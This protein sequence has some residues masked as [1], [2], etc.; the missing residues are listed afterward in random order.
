[1]FN[2]G[3]DG[4][5]LLL[6]RAKCSSLPLSVQMKRRSWDYRMGYEESVKENRL[7]GYREWSSLILAI[8]G[9]E[10]APLKRDSRE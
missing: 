1:M 4:P 8:S 9:N 6:C 10:G 2:F 3:S 5:R 7:T